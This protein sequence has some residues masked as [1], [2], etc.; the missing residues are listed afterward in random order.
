MFGDRRQVEASRRFFGDEA[1][2]LAA[3][4]RE[5]DE[6][7]RNYWSLILS[8]LLEPWTLAGGTGLALQFGHRY[9]EDLDFFL[10]GDFETEELIDKLSEVGSLSI[11][12]RSSRT[13]HVMLD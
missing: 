2:R 1:V 10:E 3:G 8:G 12:S 7:T 5:T 13:L 4:H 6:R 11:Q 9:S